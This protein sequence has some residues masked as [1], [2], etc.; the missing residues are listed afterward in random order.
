MNDQTTRRKPSPIPA[1]PTAWQLSR[2]LEQLLALRQELAAIDPAIE[3]D[4][5]LYLDMLDG[6]GGD[7]L[8]VLTA[9]IRSS[10]ADDRRAEAAKAHK[11]DIAARQ[12]GFE[13]SRDLKRRAAFAAFET[14]NL[15]RITEWDF[16]AYRHKGVPHV[17]I[18]NID[19]SALGAFVR[20]EKVPDKLGIAAELRQGKRLDGAELS[21]PEPGLT[22]RTR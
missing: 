16:T 5:R 14:L 21:N 15:P 3:D 19:A 7:A 11:A 20:I 10:I 6:E 13:R 18:T 4:P 1:E 9:T 17:L 22:V 2:A 12:A 8:S